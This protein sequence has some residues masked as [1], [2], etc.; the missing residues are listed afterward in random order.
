[1]KNYLLENGQFFFDVSNCELVCEES[2]ILESI[3]ELL[4][5]IEKIIHGLDGNFGTYEGC[6]I[7]WIKNIINYAKEA[8]NSAQ[9]GNFVSFAMMQRSIVENYVCACFIKRYKEERLWE[10]WFVSS[11]ASSS[12]MLNKLTGNKGKYERAQLD[13]D[14]FCVELGVSIDWDV[15]ST[16]GWTSEILKKKR[17]TFLDLCNNINS[18][19]YKDYRWLCDYA[20]GVTAINKIYRFTF[21]ESYMYLL[22]TFVLYIQRSVEELIVDVVDQSY[23]NQKQ[24]F[25]DKMKAW[26]VKYKSKY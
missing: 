17:P 1:M 9:L 12:Y 4:L 23:W 6:C 7:L 14:K 10:K 21:I 13:I 3:Y 22:T 26:E 5:V 15:K 16:Y 2:E 11:M 24:I 19:Y 18:N 25:W 20:H 8:F